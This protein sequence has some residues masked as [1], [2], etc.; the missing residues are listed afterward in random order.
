MGL[1]HNDSYFI[2]PG[3]KPNLTQNTY[4]VT[5]NQ[6]Y[7]SPDRLDIGSKYQYDVYADAI[8][9]LTANSKLLDIGSGPPQ[10]LNHFLG[11]DKAGVWLVDQPSTSAL[12]KHLL[13][14]ANFV[15]ANLENITIDLNI[16]FDIII[17]A[18]VI[19]HLVDPD[20]CLAFIQ[21][22]LEYHG[23]AFISTP[24]RDVLRGRHCMSSP[25]PMHVREWNKMEF[26]MLLEDRNFLVERQYLLP[27]KRL[28]AWKKKLAKFM[29]KMGM[30]PRWYS[31]Q[32]AV[33]RNIHFQPH[34]SVPNRHK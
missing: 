32:V 8:Q 20:P 29:Y 28:P 12:A 33:C 4:D 10:K 3:Y 9:L 15:S 25:H 30:P 26:R 34:K 1:Q 14:H 31:C 21:R 22:H 2:K 13:P 19:E 23:S 7:W 11:R 6:T 18:D 17:C 5:D 27:Q 16:R 24:E